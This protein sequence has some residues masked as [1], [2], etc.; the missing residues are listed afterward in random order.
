VEPAAADR[1]QLLDEHLADLVVGEREPL[2][3]ARLQQ[4]GGARLVE[5]VEQRVSA[6]REDAASSSNEKPCPPPPRVE[7]VRARRAQASSRPSDRGFTLCGNREV[8]DLLAVPAVAE[9]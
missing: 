3:A 4:L 2:G 8:V 6:A 5:R 9:R 7:R 1:V